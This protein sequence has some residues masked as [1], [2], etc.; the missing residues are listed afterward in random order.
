VTHRALAAIEIPFQTPTD[1]GGARATRVFRQVDEAAYTFGLLEIGVQFHANYLRRDR[2]ETW[3]ELVVIC[4]L[5]GARTVD[6]G[7]LSRATFNF[8]SAQAR[9]QRA[10]QL[11]DMSKAPE[12]DWPRLLEELC[13]KVLTAH[14]AGEPAVILRDVERPKPD[15][16][17]TVDGLTLLRRHPV[18]LFGD[19]GAAKSY[20]ALY[21]GGRLAQQGL[22]VALFDW[23][24]A[25]ED[26]RDRYERLFGEGMPESFW[27]VRC[28]HPL[29]HEL[30]H[31]RLLARQHAFDYGIFDSVGFAAHEKP[32]T[33]E[34]ALSYFRANRQIGLG[35]LNIAHVTKSDE[36]S[37]QKPFGSSFWHNGARATYFMKRSSE[38]ADGREITVGLFNRK[39][40]L[41][42]LQPAFGFTFSFDE[43]RTLVRRSNLADSDDFAAQ[44]PL[45]QRIR[46]LLRG[47]AKTIAAIAEELDAKPNS[48]TQTVKRGKGKLFTL[49]LSPDGVQR[50]GLLEG[51]AHE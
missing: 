6:G 4:E 23:E 20:L 49:I 3:G 27:Y 32:E 10:K 25:G 24:L 36:G 14:E 30:D 38:S 2:F 51:H 33:A 15:A 8:S 11:A 44:L 43:E 1:G 39:A 9:H 34:A 50:I 22:R 21:L 19:G 37:D 45:T 5:A 16:V 41:G 31:L 12:L 40:N 17:L 42:R 48:V 28:R 35:S 47:G 13:T 18:V 7:V 46:H 29:V 26:H